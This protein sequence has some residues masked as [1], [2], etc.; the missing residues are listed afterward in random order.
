VNEGGVYGEAGHGGLGR[1]LETQWRGDNSLGGKAEYESEGANE[2]VGLV[3]K[4]F[5]W[6][7][8]LFECHRD[9]SQA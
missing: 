4:S 7:L 9:L 1:N 8:E 2:Q 6:V 5:A 3:G